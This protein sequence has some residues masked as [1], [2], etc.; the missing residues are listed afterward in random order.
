MSSLFSFVIFRFHHVLIV[1]AAIL[2]TIPCQGQH[3]AQYIEKLKVSSTP[4]NFKEVFVDMVTV[5]KSGKMNQFEE[6]EVRQIVD[7]ALGKPFSD[8]ILPE[9]YGWAGTMFGSGRMEQ[10]L[11]Y[12]YGKC[13][14][15]SPTK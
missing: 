14:V 12:I 13:G 4:E 9:V 15:I 7:I 10:A 1:V 8:I 2:F 3:A 11:L 5:Y 6:V